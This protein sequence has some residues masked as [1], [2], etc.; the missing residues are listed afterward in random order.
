MNLTRRAVLAGAAA[1]PALSHIASG[2]DTAAITS[3]TLP[4][5]SAFA[6]MP[7]TYLAS[8][9]THPMSLGAKAA[10]EEYL[11]F[12]TQDGSVQGYSVSAMEEA[13]L[14]SFGRLIGAQPEELSFIQ[15][16]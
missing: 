12:K 14:A 16:T 3:A 5:K 10:L 2:A 11:R 15:S 4:A 9:S 6:R 1:L 7:M 13:V 8:G